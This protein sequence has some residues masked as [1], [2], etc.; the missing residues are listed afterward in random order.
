[1]TVS[2]LCRAIDRG[3]RRTRSFNGENFT[4]DASDVWGDIEG[5]AS[6]G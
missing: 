6:D 4:F 5:R 3:E 1:M 2:E